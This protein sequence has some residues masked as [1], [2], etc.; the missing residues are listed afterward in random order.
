MLF[1]KLHYTNQSSLLLHST[2]ILEKSS[3]KTNTRTQFSNHP[4][5]KSSNQKLNKRR[6]LTY[7]QFLLNK[8][9]SLLRSLG[10]FF[11]KN[12]GEI[13]FN[14]I[15]RQRNREFRFLI[16]LISSS[17]FIIDDTSSL[18]NANF[19]FFS[20][21]TTRSSSHPQIPWLSRRNYLPVLRSSSSSSCK[22]N[23]SYGDGSIGGCVI[24]RGRRRRRRW[25]IDA[26]EESL[27]TP[28][29]LRQREV[30]ETFRSFKRRLHCY[31]F[32]FFFFDFFC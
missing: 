12:K 10:R 3:A 4:K 6:L 32:F 21:F 27:L 26:S 28:T 9:W 17:I 24:G 23:S 30:V 18:I 29:E 14:F 20:R 19:N 22:R 31:V 25:Q 8:P 7:I 13:L 5:K 15:S 2:T 1:P 16:L 11:P